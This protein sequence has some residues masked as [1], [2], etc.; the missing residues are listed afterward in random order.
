[1]GS[2]KFVRQTAG[3]PEIAAFARVVRV[4]QRIAAIA[5]R[6]ALVGRQRRVHQLT[7]TTGAPYG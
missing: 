6:V 2:S 5:P 3:R 7:V 4:L 1:M